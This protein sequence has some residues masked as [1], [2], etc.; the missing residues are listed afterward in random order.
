MKTD[1][2]QKIKN[3]LQGPIAVIK[4]ISVYIVIKDAR[5]VF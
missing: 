3:V 5:L 4:G 2:K 1:I